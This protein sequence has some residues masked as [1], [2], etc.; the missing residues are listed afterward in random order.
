MFALGELL[1]IPDAARSPTTGSRAIRDG[2]EDR[3]YGGWFA[4]DPAG[5]PRQGGLRALVRAARRAPARRSPA[6]PAARAARGGGGGDDA[7]LLVGGAKAPPGGVGRRGEQTEPYRGA[8]ANMHMV[9]AFLAAGD[10]TGEPRWF[11]RARCG[12]PSG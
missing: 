11:D 4:E 5:V 6:R 3:E 12:S 1:G 9:E 2:F 7:P 10:A 8:N